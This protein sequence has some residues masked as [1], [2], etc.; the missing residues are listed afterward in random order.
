MNISQ[1]MLM[2]GRTIPKSALIFYSKL[3][4]IS[5][6]ISGASVGIYSYICNFSGSETLTLAHLTS[7]ITVIQKIGTSTPTIGT[8]SISFSAGTMGYLLL[9]D[10]TE[11]IFE[12]DPARN[13]AKIYNVDGTGRHGT[14]VGGDAAPFTHASADV[15]WLWRRGGALGVTNGVELSSTVSGGNATNFITALGDN[16]FRWHG[17]GS[18]FTYVRFT[19]FV[20]GGTYRLIPTVI[21]RSAGAVKGTDAS[22]SDLFVAFTATPAQK[23]DV[24][25]VKIEF[26]R[27]VSGQAIDITV[28]F[29][30]QRVVADVCPA[31]K[32]VS[33]KDV[34]GNNLSFSSFAQAGF[35]G[36]VNFEATDDLTAA[37]NLLSSPWMFTAGVPNNITPADWLAFTGGSLE[38]IMFH[39][40]AGIAV[41]SSAQSATITDRIL[42]Y[43]GG[44]RTMVI[45]LF[46]DNHWD[47]N[48]TLNTA[49]AIDQF[50]ARGVDAVISVGDNYEASL[51]GEW[52][53]PEDM[54]SE[55]ATYESLF[56]AWHLRNKSF[57]TGNHSY[58]TY[59][60]FADFWAESSLV[61]KNSVKI[62]RDIAV[63]NIFDAYSP[64]YTV[65]AATLTYLTEELEAA[66][67]RGNRIIIHTHVPLD[68]PTAVIQYGDISSIITTATASGANIL[69]IFTGHEHE[70]VAGAFAG[71]AHYRLDGLRE[72]KVAYLLNITATALTLETITG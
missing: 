19:G 44:N 42:R 11:L 52:T 65:D 13:Q 69:A 48:V 37:D 39:T 45:G 62:F 15:S 28:Q 23:D 16:T 22:D 50:E 7:A 9:S 57:S 25:T 1:Q 43:L 8:G 66:R 31:S 2:F 70:Y 51:N 61:Q 18:S 53:T 46:T 59:G 60:V 32:T 58:P 34:L 49:W 5:D 12:G 71:V 72:T 27:A 35:P 63:I 40:A 29:S 41:Y 47:T 4:E 67:L 6:R 68:S 38:N 20:A 24:I 21:S 33:G 54:Q 64:D 36:Y 10:G 56:S 3:P 55:I 17:D 30:V 14:L 26:G